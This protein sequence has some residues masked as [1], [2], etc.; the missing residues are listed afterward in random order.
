M[1]PDQYRTARRRLGL[2]HAGVAALFAVDPRTS[3]R[4]QSGEQS[5]PRSVVIAMRLMIKF[6]VSPEE[7]P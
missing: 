3:R 6:K 2:S 5:I 7:V 1:T 4:W